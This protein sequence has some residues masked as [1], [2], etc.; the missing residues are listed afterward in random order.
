MQGAFLAVLNY[1]KQN[2]TPVIKSLVLIDV[3]KLGLVIAGCET[4]DDNRLTCLKCSQGYH[5]GQDN[6][7]FKDIENCAVYSGNLCLA[8]SGNNLL[9]ANKCTSQC[10]PYCRPNIY[11][12]LG[13]PYD[14]KCSSFNDNTGKCSSCVSGFAVDKNFGS[15]ISI[16]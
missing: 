7:C 5:L 10:G 16:A 14:L 2:N 11:P 8:C 4:P 1:N 6:F 12:Y 13:S 9:I 3:G 15:C